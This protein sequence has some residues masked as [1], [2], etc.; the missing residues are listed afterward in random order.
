[1]ILSAPFPD[2][3]M[4][5]IA[6][7]C[8]RGQLAVAEFEVAGLAHIESDWTVPRQNPLAL[9]VAHRVNLTVTARAPIVRFASVQEHV[10][11]EDTSVG[12]HARWLVAAFLVWSRFSKVDDFLLREVS[13]IV[14]SFYLPLELGRA[15]NNRV[16]Q[17]NITIVGDL[18][19][20]TSSHPVGL[21][22]CGNIRMHFFDGQTLFYK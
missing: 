15:K 13:H 22:R 3:L 11:W 14:H 5:P 2:V 7:R 20:L 10:G 6:E 8:I 21:D 9:S 16:L 1:M 12:G 4:C 19:L 18:M 17:H